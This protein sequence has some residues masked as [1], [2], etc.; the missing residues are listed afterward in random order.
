MRNITM[1]IVLSMVCIGI[2]SAQIKLISVDKPLG[3]CIAGFN[4]TEDEFRNLNPRLL[5][6]VCDNNKCFFTISIKYKIANR[7]EILQSK[8]VKFSFSEPQNTTDLKS[9]I[10]REMN[11]LLIS[12]DGRKFKPFAIDNCTG[13]RGSGSSTADT[14]G[15]EFQK[16]HIIAF[17]KND[18]TLLVIYSEFNEAKVKDI[19]GSFRIKCP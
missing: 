5:D 6:F 3:D 17:Y 4:V 10:E 19:L 8:V 15:F 11:N 14:R 18:R 13:V 16:M 1:I 9:V 7:D 12:E 2:S